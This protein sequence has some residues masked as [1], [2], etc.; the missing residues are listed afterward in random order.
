[1]K[2]PEAYLEPTT[3]REVAPAEVEEAFMKANPGLSPAAISMTCDSKRLNEVRICLSKDLQFHDCA[4][5][6]RRSC[7][8]PKVVMPAVRGGGLATTQ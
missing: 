6:E 5:L 7:K 2:I 4:E 8:R 1:V 3:A